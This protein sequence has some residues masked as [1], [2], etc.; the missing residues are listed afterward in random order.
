MQKKLELLRLRSDRYIRPRLGRNSRIFGRGICFLRNSRF[1]FHVLFLRFS[2]LHRDNGLLLYLFCFV[3]LGNHFLHALHS[4][5]KRKR[6]IASL[7]F[8]NVFLY[9]IQNL[10]GNIADILKREIA[11]F[12][13]CIRNGLLC[14]QYCLA[15][16]AK[17]LQENISDACR[18]QPHFFALHI[19]SG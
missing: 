15:L 11:L 14:K 5:T 6:F 16:K 18:K 17:P 1:L 7:P 4:G 8:L 19:F 9:P 12:E 13:S 3:V 2:S 10:T